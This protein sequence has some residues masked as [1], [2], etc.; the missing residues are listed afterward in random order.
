MY[1]AFLA[2]MLNSVFVLLEA[3]S[4]YLA[5]GIIRGVFRTLSNMMELL[6]KI[7]NGV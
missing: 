7:R 1:I 6:V 3:L 5:T 4:Q 2:S